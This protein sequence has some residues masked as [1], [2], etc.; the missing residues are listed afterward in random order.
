MKKML[1]S[2][3]AFT[4]VA[5]S[6]VAVAPTTSEAIPAFARQTGAACLSCHFSEVPALAPFGRAFKEGSFTMVGDEA[7]VESDNLSIPT[8]LNAAMQVRMNIHHTSGG[9]VPNASVTT[10]S[11]P[12]DAALMVAGRVGSHTGAFVE[13]GGGVGNTGTAFNN[14]QLLNSFDVGNFKVGGGFADTSFGADAVM[15]VSSVYGQHSGAQGDV[16]GD[17]GAINNSGYTNSI[18]SIAVWGGNDL[19]YIQVGLVAPGGTAGW[20]AASPISGASVT[21]GITNIGSNLAKSVRA[22]VTIGVGN[23]DI[24]AGGG[25]LT[26][27]AGKAGTNTSAGVT[28]NVTGWDMR[29][30][31]LDAQAQ[32]TIS[33]MPVGIYADWAHAKGTTMGNLMGAQDSSVG[34]LKTGDQFN[35]ASLRATIKPVTGLSFALGYGYRELQAGA[36]TGNTNNKHK[37]TDVAVSYQLYQNSIL[38]LKYSSDRQTIGNAGYTVNTTSLDW[39]TL[40]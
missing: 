38:S 26:G 13:F 1:L 17:V 9:P 11:I 20:N 18:S 30:Q 16:G 35:A 34:L 31:F 33:D 37:V 27:K 8:V 3:A 5:V 14:V 36:R 10:Y 19:G 22:A 24:V 7:L 40:M 23:F 29:M 21:Q 39:L 12:T 2:A 4:V 6:A 28:T 32:G 15:N 25:F